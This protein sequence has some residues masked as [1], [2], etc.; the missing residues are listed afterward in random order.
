MFTAIEREH[1]GYRDAAALLKTAQHNLE[2][3]RA[4]AP[5]PATPPASPPPLVERVNR[6]TKIVLAAV[7]LV[8]VVV[9]GVGAILLVSHESPQLELHFTGLSFPEGVAV[10]SAGTVYVA[11][12]NNSR[13]LKLPAVSLGMRSGLAVSKMRTLLDNTTDAV[14]RRRRFGLTCA[15]FGSD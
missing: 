13:V 6:R 11:D 7:A 10:D 15:L 12:Y 3:A 2:A 4:E 8:V 9:A 14:T 1:P 5:Q